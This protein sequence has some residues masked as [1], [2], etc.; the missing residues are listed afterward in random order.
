MRAGRSAW[1][2]CALGLT[3]PP[4]IPWDAWRTSHRFALCAVCGGRAIG[5]DQ[6]RSF[7]F[8]AQTERP[9]VGGGHLGERRKQ[10]SRRVDQVSG[11]VQRSNVQSRFI[12]YRA[13]QRRAPP[14][15]A[16]QS[17]M[18]PSA[19]TAD[20]AALA[21]RNGP[22]RP[23]HNGCRSIR[24][25][26]SIAFK[27]HRFSSFFWSIHG[28][29]RRIGMKQLTSSVASLLD[30]CGMPRRLDTTDNG[31]P[32]PASHPHGVRQRPSHPHDR[33]PARFVAIRQRDHR[34]RALI[35]T[36]SCRACET[37]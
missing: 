27:R 37:G 2:A 8:L 16:T 36:R 4:G 13:A 32:H 12:S 21:W 14:S 10:L 29:A 18:A 19:E 5:G 24:I 31:A 22:L 3:C 6:K 25:G 9:F 34:Q 7:A 17:R 15:D 23:N 20:E 28:G 30:R 35:A 11:N 33:G 1:H 26:R